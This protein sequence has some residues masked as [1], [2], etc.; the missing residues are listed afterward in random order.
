MAVI[1]ADVVHTTGIYITTL[2][3]GRV[4]IG[5]GTR[6]IQFH[7]SC[8]ST[9]CKT[10]PSNCVRPS[11]IVDNP[12][13]VANASVAD[14]GQD[15][16]DSDEHRMEQRSKYLNISL[17]VEEGSTRCNTDIAAAHGP[18]TSPSTF[19]KLIHP[20]QP[21]ISRSTKVFTTLNVL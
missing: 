10:S 7:I 6:R 9:K 17:T 19:Q 13:G 8:W 12:I 15:P 16:R 5:T 20:D 21:S 11:K 14:E 1:P 4:P 3:H 2:F 18:W